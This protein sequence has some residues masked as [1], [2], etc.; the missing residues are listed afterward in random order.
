METSTQHHRPNGDP[1]YDMRGVSPR[2]VGENSH[3]QVISVS[4]HTSPRRVQADA[5]LEERVAVCG[6]PSQ[7]IRLV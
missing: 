7:T 2:K 1:I 5:D 4:F 3:L 6:P